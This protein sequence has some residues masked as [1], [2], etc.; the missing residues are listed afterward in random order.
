MGFLLEAHDVI[1]REV[2]W[3]LKNL[4]SLEVG[5]IFVD[6]TSTCFEI[7]GEVRDPG[8]DVDGDDA[9]PGLR[10]RGCSKDSR[11]DVAQVV[12]GLAVTRDGIPVCCWVW[13]ATPWTSRSSTRS[14][15]IWTTGRWVG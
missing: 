11:A 6:T 15:A 13:P 14:S 12:L 10:K 9:E 4:F 2:F 7:G 3:S 5:L 8:D 1:R